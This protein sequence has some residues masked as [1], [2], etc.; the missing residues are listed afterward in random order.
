MHSTPPT[1]GLCFHTKQLNMFLQTSGLIIPL[2]FL[3]ELRSGIIVFWVK[4]K[5]ELRI[6]WLIVPIVTHILPYEGDVIVLKNGV[7]RVLKVS[8]SLDQHR[9]EEGSSWSGH[10]YKIFSLLA[11]VLELG[12][13]VVVLTRHLVSW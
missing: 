11:W 9:I 3:L 5:C 7:S 8:R 13:R 2:I 4:G 12:T 6:W 1:V 10:F